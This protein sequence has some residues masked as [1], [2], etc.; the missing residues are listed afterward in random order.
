MTLTEP[1]RPR[2]LVS[3]I[4]PAYNCA[5]FVGDAIRSVL[6]QGYPNLQ[7]IAVNDGSTDPTLSVLRTFG[8]DVL[9]LDRANGGAAAARNTGLRH[10]KGD[11]IAFLDGD[12]IW[13]PG[14]LDVQVRYLEDHSEVGLVFTDWTIWEE[15]PD[16]CRTESAPADGGSPDGAIDPSQSGWLY[17][18][19]LLE[20]ILNTSTV[21]IRSPIVRRIGEFDESLKNGQDYDYW[22][23]VSR[24]AEIH[25]LAASLA[26]YR[27]HGGNSTHQPKPSNYAYIVLTR[28]LARWGPR[29]PDGRAPDPAALR[30]RLAGLCFSFA[31]NRYWSGDA[32]RARASLGQCLRHR[33]LWLRPWL[34]L[35]LSL[36]PRRPRP[37]RR[38]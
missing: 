22:L 19:L 18:Q 31:R 24:V 20:C 7:I 30:N 13:F 12:D 1:S 38:S 32:A 14:K 33:P 36:V 35:L 5:A 27:H 11:F 21:V 10:A 37:A 26:V 8:D 15:S 3:V 2:P 25:K 6:Q 29:G 4:V 17:H 23:R 28:A 16:G 9:V 34:Y